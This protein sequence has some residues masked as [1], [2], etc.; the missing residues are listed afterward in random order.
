[1]HFE[2]IYLVHLTIEV[3][4]SAEA[5]GA[6]RRGVGRE[7]LPSVILAAPKPNSHHL[8]YCF[9][10]KKDNMRDFNELKHIF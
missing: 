4:R 5:L 2:S 7:A 6:K 1:V 8:L 10:S 3:A 9:Q